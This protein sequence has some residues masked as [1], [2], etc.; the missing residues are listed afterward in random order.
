[1]FAGRQPRTEFKVPTWGTLLRSMPQVLEARGLV[2]AR[3]LELCPIMLALLFARG[4][5]GTHN[6]AELSQHT[7]FE[8]RSTHSPQQLL[9]IDDISPAGVPVWNV[10]I[11][12]PDFAAE[13]P[14]RQVERRSVMHPKG[15]HFN[16]PPPLT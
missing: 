12:R 1:M 6:I 11:P 15:F 10:D 9:D 3:W 14:L 8:S 16:R 2:V 5:I 13:S 4:S 7:A